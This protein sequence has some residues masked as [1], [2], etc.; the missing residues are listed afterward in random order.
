MTRIKLRYV[1]AFINKKSGLVF[2]Y[3]RRPGYPRVRL[4]GLPGSSEF[5]A[6]Y[7]A[8]LA[9]QP[10][11][12]GAGKVKP[13]S[14]A[15]T[16]AAY[17][18]SVEWR[19]TAIGTQ[20]QRRSV[21]ERFRAAHGDKPIAMLPQEFI[22]VTLSSLPPFAARNWL[23][24]LRALLQFAV[25]RKLRADDPTQGIRLPRVKSDGI[26]TWTEDDIAAFET[27]HPIGGK[28][29]L[30]LSLLLYTAQRRGD[31]IKMGRQHVRD[32]A[33]HVRQQ[34]TGFALAIPIHPDLQTV[35]TV[36]PRDQLTFLVTNAGKP[37]TGTTFSDQFRKWCDEAG[38]PKECSAHGLR[39]A[40]CRRLAEAG[41][42]ANE[43]ASISGHASLREVERY[44][45]AVDQA[46]MARNAIARTENISATPTVK[47]SGLFD[48]NAS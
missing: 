8:A 17:Y 29:R 2:R 36:T 9:G 22:V 14:V 24:A 42:S 1:Q 45:K 37:Y 25:A 3:F 39:K 41:C 23:K 31:V 30:A 6:A 26:Y 19:S 38:L 47:K 21:L 4:P 15:A 46:R 32:D 44:T 12:I 33:L 18:E 28:A 7:Q 34:K 16:I 20:A 11:R 5:N 27:K 48:S 35:L 43:I 10:L 40:A 13:G